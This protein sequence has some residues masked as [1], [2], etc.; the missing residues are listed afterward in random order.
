MFNTVCLTYAVMCSVRTVS[1]I[2]ILEW[3]SVVYTHVTIKENVVNF[4]IVVVN[5]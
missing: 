4:L 1:K 5:V 2:Y 3:S